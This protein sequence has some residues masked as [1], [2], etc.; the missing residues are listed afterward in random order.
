MERLCNEKVALY[1]ECIGSCS[2]PIFDPAWWAVSEPFGYVLCEHQENVRA[3]VVI[4]R[5]LEVSAMRRKQS[6][7]VCHA[8]TVHRQM[9][10]RLVIGGLSTRMKV[11]AGEVK[12]IMLGKEVDGVGGEDMAG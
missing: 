6:Q 12:D 9:V 8:T 7:C 10:A 5:G 3:Q 1:V 2:N 11:E 4:A